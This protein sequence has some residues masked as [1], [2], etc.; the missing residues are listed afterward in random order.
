MQTGDAPATKEDIKELRTEMK[1]LRTEMKAMEERLNGMEERLTGMEERLTEAIRDSQT[2][3]LKAFYGYTQT[4][5]I[6]LK[7]R[8]ASDITLRQRVGVIESRLLEV[9]RRLNMPPQ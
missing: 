4:T 6:R 5:E 3:I 1:E 9:E 2:E 7:E 8:E